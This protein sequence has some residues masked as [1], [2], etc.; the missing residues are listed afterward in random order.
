ML[1][2]LPAAAAAAAAAAA[3]TKDAKV[4]SKVGDSLT[5]LPASA[6]WGWF[7]SEDCDDDGLCGLEKCK[8]TCTKYNDPEDPPDHECTG[9]AWVPDRWDRSFLGWFKTECWRCSYGGPKGEPAT[10]KECGLDSGAGN[11]CPD[12]FADDYSTTSGDEDAAK[13]SLYR[14]GSRCDNGEAPNYGGDTY[15][16][17]DTSDSC[18]SCPVGTY[19]RTGAT[20]CAACDVGKFADKTGSSVCKPCAEP[21][22]NV[23]NPLR[24]QGPMKDAKD[25]GETYKCQGTCYGGCAA[26][27]SQGASVQQGS[28]WL[29]KT[30]D[31]CSSLRGDSA[32][33]D[34]S[35]LTEEQAKTC[36]DSEACTAAEVLLIKQE[37]VVRKMSRPCSCTS[38]FNG[39]FCSTKESAGWSGIFV[40]FVLSSVILTASYYEVTWNVNTALKE[41]GDDSI[42]DWMEKEARKHATHAHGNEDDHDHRHEHEANHNHDDD[43]EVE[44]HMKRLSHVPITIDLLK[45]T[46]AFLQ[47]G[48]VAFKD[49]IQWTALWA[50]PDWLSWPNFFSVKLGYWGYGWQLFLYI[51][52]LAGAMII[53][54]QDGE[55]GGRAKK[56]FGQGTIRGLVEGLG[57]NYEEQKIKWDAKSADKKRKAAEKK[58]RLRE[59]MAER[60]DKLAVISAFGD[61]QAKKLPEESDAQVTNEID[62]EAE[63]AAEDTKKFLEDPL[64]FL[65]G[66][67]L[68][69]VEVLMIPAVKV[70][71]DTPR[72]YKRMHVL[73]AAHPAVIQIFSAPFAGCTYYSDRDNTFDSDPTLSCW[74]SAAWVVYL[75]ICCIAFFFTFKISNLAAMQ[76]VENEQQPVLYQ[77]ALTLSMVKVHKATSRSYRLLF[78]LLL[79][80][81]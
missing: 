42:D 53:V 43:H 48:A 64:S 19:A 81:P 26:D 16:D 61:G 51:T 59:N 62:D 14:H 34:P 58:Q 70:Q 76:L 78:C 56:A 71:K 10:W 17:G 23:C 22:M 38:G 67:A 9:V 35:T 55:T 52:V 40:A 63:E 28:D 73:P 21:V 39:R 69:L 65:P 3:E 41:Q 15:G 36:D 12:A 46:W 1:A 60:N 33:C 29:F 74:A 27:G 75:V 11:E 24:S 4:W 66:F 6:Q 31:H 45:Q 32:S 80:L 7:S 54:I 30:A 44:D 57:M 68:G 20:E 25:A 79:T 2:A 5:C 47:L 49:T 77:Y 8:A 37:S 72:C 18:K 13:I 50:L